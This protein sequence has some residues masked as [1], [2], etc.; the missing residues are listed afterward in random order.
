MSHNLIENAFEP[1]KKFNLNDMNF[2]LAF[3][4]EGALDGVRRNDPRYVQQ[5]VRYFGQNIDGERFYRSIPFHDCTE[6]DLAQFNPVAPMDKKRFEGIMKDPKRGMSCIDFEK[7]DLVLQSSE[8]LVTVFQKM[9]IVLAPCNVYSK[10]L[11]RTIA[12]INPECIPDL[13]K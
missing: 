13:E 1:D 10:N 7:E 5:Y 3:T 12:D 11:N 9:D 8:T 2:R 6:A 4:F